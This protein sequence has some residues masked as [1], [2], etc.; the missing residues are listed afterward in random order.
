[1]RSHPIV[2]TLPDTLKQRDET[3]DVRTDL[4]AYGIGRF[5]WIHKD[6][7][8]AQLNQIYHKKLIG[9]TPENRLFAYRALR[10]TP[11][12]NSIEQAKKL[13]DEPDLHLSCEAGEGQ[14]FFYRGPDVNGSD[15]C[16]LMNVKTL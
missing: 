3:E 11:V 13:L 16:P 12:F 6:P 4:Q 9:M 5:Y 15:Q 14:C 7:T 1:M 2:E 8:P 10:L